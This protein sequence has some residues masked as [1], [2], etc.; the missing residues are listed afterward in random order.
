MIYYE[1]YDLYYC[2]LIFFLF[3]LMDPDVDVAR[4]WH[5]SLATDRRV[6]HRRH[7]CSPSGKQDVIS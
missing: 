5:M 6:H 7:I 2:S 1:G 4:A 3:L